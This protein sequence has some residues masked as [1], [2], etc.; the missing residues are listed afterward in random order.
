MTQDLLKVLLAIEK[1]Q[2]R[3]RKEKWGARTLDLDI[4]CYDNQMI[5]Q[6]KLTIPHYD[7]KNRAFFIKPLYDIAPDLI[8]PDGIAIKD[9]IKNFSNAKLEV[10]V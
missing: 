4:L 6:K 9:L 3:E 10:V 2:G 7:L 5:K 8:L 1:Q